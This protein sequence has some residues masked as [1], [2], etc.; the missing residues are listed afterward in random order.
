MGSDDDRA[1]GVTPG[2]R[3]DYATRTV[4]RQ[5]AFVLP[6]LREGM[7]LLDIGCG[8][9]TITLGLAQAVYP[10][11]V[12]GVDHDAAHV[13]AAS[14]LVAERGVTNVT[15]QEGDAMALQFEDGAFDAVFENDLFTHLSQN[16]PRAASEVYRVL[17][18]GGLFGAR[19]V[20][21]EAVVWGHLTDPIEQL[22][23]L[24]L[25]WQQGRGSDI[26]LGNRLPAIL[27]QAGFTRTVKSVS[28]DTKGDAEAV[29]AHARITIFL[30]DGPL[31]RDALANG[32]ADE[33]TLEHIKASTLAWAEHPDAFFAN[34]HVEVVGWKPGRSDD[35]QA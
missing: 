16:A 14:A 6:Y 8:P 10:G 33:P 18:P 26:T 28:A 22:D 5:G 21:A 25:A 29:R 30:L 12:V 17:K 27:R 31:G 4:S 20:D 19:D 32:W 15:F 3:Q 34:M 1:H 11:H 35:T 7:N 2:L 9:G 23:R 24:M 13:K